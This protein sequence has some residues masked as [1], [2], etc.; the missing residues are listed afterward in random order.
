M[1]QRVSSHHNDSIVIVAM[2]DQGCNVDLL[3]QSG[4]GGKSPLRGYCKDGQA[5]CST[6]G[7]SAG[8]KLRKIY[9]SSC[10]L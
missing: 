7:Q 8:E 9:S 6:Q 1:A 3:Y 5:G 10:L 4:P 2:R